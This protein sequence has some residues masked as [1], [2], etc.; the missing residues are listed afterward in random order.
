MTSLPAKSFGLKDRGELRPGTIADI[1]IFDPA[2]V[3]D[4]STFADPHHYALGFGD[5]VVNGVPV[6]RDGTLTGARPGRPVKRGE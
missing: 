2:T 6:I 1:V 3:A 5:V 4:P